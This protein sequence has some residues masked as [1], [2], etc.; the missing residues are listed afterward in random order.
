MSS[1]NTLAMVLEVVIAA[2]TPIVVALGNETVNEAL[3]FAVAEHLAFREEPIL[4]ILD[5][6]LAAL[7]AWQ[8]ILAEEHH[9]NE[10]YDLVCVFL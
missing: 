1:Q 10:H 8:V 7:E 9:L 5:S 3:C 6:L 2:R 4:Q